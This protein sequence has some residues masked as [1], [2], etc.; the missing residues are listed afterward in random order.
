MR[1]KR[2]PALL[3]LVLSGWISGCTLIKGTLQ[4]PDLA[5]QALLPFTQRQAPP[6]PVEVQSKVIRFSVQ[7]LEAVTRSMRLL[8]RDGEPIGRRELTRRRIQYSNE[9]LAIAAGSNAFANLL[10]MVVLVT[11]TRMRVENYWKLQARNVEL[12]PI[13]KVFSA[14]ESEIWRISATVL[15][16]EQQLELRAALSD[17]LK[18]NPKLRFT[19]DMADLDFVSEIR[20]FS[21]VRTSSAPASV[22]NLLMID[23]L[24]GLDPAAKELAETRL[25]AERALFLSRHLP[26]LIRWETEYFTLNT[27]AIPEVS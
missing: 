10:D 12:E 25:M 21:R 4:L 17:W 13:L 14:A 20:D 18:K 6:D 22:F 5:I 8:Q 7:Y 24:S 9:V 1:L 2:W 3:A 15:R 26:E 16:P 27:V 23:P 19:P 11:L